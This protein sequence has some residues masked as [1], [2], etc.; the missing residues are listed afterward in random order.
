MG[1]EIRDVPGFCGRYQASDR[2]DVISHCR[3][4]TGSPR[5]LRQHL[6]KRGYYV[7]NLSGHGKVRQRTVHS[8]VLEAFVGPRPDGME[9]RHLNG[10]RTDNRLCNLAYGTS[11]ENNRDRNLHGTSNRGTRNGHAV[12]NPESVQD[13]RLL[14]LHG[15]SHSAIARAVGVH[16]STVK[17]IT[18]GRNWK[19]LDWPI[20]I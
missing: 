6:G 2:G 3:S 1:C 19:H 7:V 16:P 9:V 15:S 18:S 17:N 11:M 10:I 14:Y 4:A 13:I 8:L 12:L 20:A 5:I